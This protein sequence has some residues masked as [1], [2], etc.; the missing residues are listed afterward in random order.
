ML[1]RG[2]VPVTRQQRLGV[3]GGPRGWSQQN[4]TALFFRAKLN[5]G[6]ASPAAGSPGWQGGIHPVMTPYGYVTTSS[7]SE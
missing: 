5:C 7:R 6:N 3:R 1:E 2:S 4:K